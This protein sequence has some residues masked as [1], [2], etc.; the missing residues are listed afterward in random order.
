MAA[1]NPLL[2]PTFQKMDERSLLDVNVCEV[3]Q[4]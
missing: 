2:A 3:L 4:I 1:L